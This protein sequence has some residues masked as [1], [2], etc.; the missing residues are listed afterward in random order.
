MFFA[1]TGGVMLP[2]FRITVSLLGV[3]WSFWSCAGSRSECR[4]PAVDEQPTLRRLQL[5]ALR[6]AQAQH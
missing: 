5:G 1:E 3:G 6:L 2:G 4:G